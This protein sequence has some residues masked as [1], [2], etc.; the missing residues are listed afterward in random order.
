VTVQDTGAAFE[1]TNLKDGAPITNPAS[2]VVEWEVASTDEAPISCDNVDIDLLSFNADF[3]KYSALSLLLFP[4]VGTPNDG[5]E[6]VSVVLDSDTHEYVR[7]R[8]ACRNNVFYDISD[9]TFRINGL[10]PDVFSDFKRDVFY[11]NKGTTG[12]IAPV[13]GAIAKCSVAPEDS[14]GGGGSSAFDYRWL[15]LLAV[16]L[17]LVRARRASRV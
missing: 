3:S 1:I 9:V 12:G 2:F 14:G 5:I 7:V 8:V 6:T 16:L 10:G 4:L 17:L 13:C 15:A 11:N